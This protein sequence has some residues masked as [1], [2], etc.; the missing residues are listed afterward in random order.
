[1][2]QMQKAKAAPAVN[3]NHR[4]LGVMVLQRLADGHGPG[5]IRVYRTVLVE[6][7][8]GTTT[9][10][11]RL[12]VPLDPR[13]PAGTCAL[14]PADRKAFG[15]QGLC[16]PHIAYVE[17]KLLEKKAASDSHKAKFDAG[18][19][20]RLKEVLRNRLIAQLA[21]DPH[22]AAQVMSAVR[23]T[24]AGDEAPKVPMPVQRAPTL[25]DK[26]SRLLALADEVSHDIEAY[27]DRSKVGKTYDKSKLQVMLSREAAR[28]WKLCWFAFSRMFE[29]ATGTVFARRRGW[30]SDK[31]LLKLAATHEYLPTSAAP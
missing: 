9:K 15:E 6:E 11:G 12:K 16:A 24:T 28:D 8:L 22:L 4:H 18:K 29:Q 31:E 26:V 7:K 5:P 19:A 13:L 27:K 14:S 17:L 2:N 3:K 10:V 30:A 23:L 20:Q 1:M 25:S 21:A